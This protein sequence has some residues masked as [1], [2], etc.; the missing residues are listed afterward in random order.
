MAITYFE[1]KIDRKIRPLNKGFRTEFNLITG[2]DYFV[3][4]GRNIV[5]P[6]KLIG[7]TDTH[8]II[9]V[10]EKPRTNRRYLEL[11]GNAN[12]HAVSRYLLARIEIGRT[13]EEAVMNSASVTTTA[14]EY[15]R[16]DITDHP[17]FKSM[18]GVKTRTGI[19]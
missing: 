11:N 8:V 14:F 3:S 15:N 10:P 18:P 4:F 1:I 13:P 12:L 17:G 19:K 5:F 16:Y 6:C 9:E 2:A 7:T